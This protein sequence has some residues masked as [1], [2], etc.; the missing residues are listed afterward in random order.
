MDQQHVAELFPVGHIKNQQSGGH[1][2]RS[3][4]SHG[5]RRGRLEEHYT[6]LARTPGR[7]RSNARRRRRSRLGACRSP[8][9]D[10]AGARRHTIAPF[11][12]AA[13]TLT[14]IGQSVFLCGGAAPRYRQGV[15]PTF[16]ATLV[17]PGRDPLP[18]TS[19]PPVY[20]GYQ[21]RQWRSVSNRSGTRSKGAHSAHSCLTVPVLRPIL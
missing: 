10:A 17:Q 4:P 1:D 11:V 12:L 13:T 14:E 15:S 6:G 21:E 16:R 9:D 19:S 7:A 3:Q 8:L 20:L 2:A 18:L 5:D